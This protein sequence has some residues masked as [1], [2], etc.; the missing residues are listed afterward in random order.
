MERQYQ[1]MTKEQLISI[2][3]G[4]QTLMNRM[5]SKLKEQEEQVETL[6][7]EKEEVVKQSIIMELQYKLQEEKLKKV[8]KEV[9]LAKEQTKEY[10]AQMESKEESLRCFQAVIQHSYG[11]EKPVEKIAKELTSTVQ[12]LYYEEIIEFQ[13]KLYQETSSVVEKHEV[14][15]FLNQLLLTLHKANSNHEMSFEEKGRTEVK[16]GDKMEI[17]IDFVQEGDLATA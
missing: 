13:N 15:G 7:Q 4:Q 5:W 2:I 8:R 11:E 12:E 10:K 17:N 6:N 16:I 3:E 1:D 14:N 9:R